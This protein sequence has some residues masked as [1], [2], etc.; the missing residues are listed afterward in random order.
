[1]QVIN[2]AMLSITIFTI[3]ECRLGTEYMYN[4]IIFSLESL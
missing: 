2:D 3:K 4:H 1:M